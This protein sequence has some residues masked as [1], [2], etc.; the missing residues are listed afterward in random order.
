[1]RCCAFSEKRANRYRVC[2]VNFGQRYHLPGSQTQWTTVASVFHV[3]KEHLS[4]LL[5]F[6]YRTSPP[7]LPSIRMNGN[8]T[9]AAAIFMLGV[10]LYGRKYT[11]LFRAFKLS[12][13]R[14]ILLPCLALLTTKSPNLRQS[15]RYEIVNRS[16]RLENLEPPEGGPIQTFS[17]GRVFDLPL[18]VS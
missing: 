7:L 6:E 11:S 17:A 12:L 13:L 3:P 18:P 8:T 2:N 15:R 14:I 9:S 16:K 5:Y 4:T 1:M 10:F